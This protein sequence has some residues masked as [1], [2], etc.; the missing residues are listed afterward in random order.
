MGVG[1][2]ISRIRGLLLK[3]SHGFNRKSCQP[4][5]TDHH[6]VEE[7]QAAQIY[8]RRTVVNQNFEEIS[9]CAAQKQTDR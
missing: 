1:V 5:R 3:L 9:H 6:Q 7:S 4:S 2:P 8:F